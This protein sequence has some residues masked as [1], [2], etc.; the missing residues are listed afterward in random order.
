MK[1]GPIK[2][3]LP[4]SQNMGHY[5]KYGAHRL[6]I[7]YEEIYKITEI[8]NPESGVVKIEKC[9]YLNSLRLIPPPVAITLKISPPSPTYG[10]IIGIHP[11]VFGIP[12]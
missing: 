4:P 3:H 11:P 2:P 8:Q 7:R 5:P 9:W 10:G 1:I 12:I 6:A